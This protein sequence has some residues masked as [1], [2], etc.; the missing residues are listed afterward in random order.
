MEAVKSLQ[1]PA[2]GQKFLW[3]SELRGF[4]V[5][6][7]PS[8]LKTFILQ[9]RN[10]EDR[11]RRIAL[12]RFG[13][14]TVEQARVAAKVKLGD[15]AKGLDP[16]EGGGPSD[17]VTINEVCEWY[18]AEAGSGRLLGR[19]NRPIKTSTL[20]MDRSRI[21]MHIKPLLGHRQVKALKAIDIAAMQ[22]DI[23]AGKTARAK[24][25]GRGGVT[26]GGPGVAARTLTTLQ[27]L[28]SHAK[29]MDVV[30]DNP[31]V[32]VRKIA[33][34]KRD[35]RLSAGE[36]TKLGLAMRNSGQWAES[37]TALAAVRL[38]ILTGFRISEAQEL[39]RAWVNTEKRFVQFPDTKSGAQVRAIGPS[40]AALIAEQG[41]S[42]T[43]PYVF[44]ADVGDGAYTAAKRCLA[45]LCFNANITGV[46]PHTL[47]HTF[48][49]VAGDLG[50]SELTIAALLGHSARG[51]TQGY[52]HIDEALKLAAERTCEEIAGLLKIDLAS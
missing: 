30:A 40:A 41:S 37:P 15:I 4:G 3:D 8:G 42:G 46:T 22:A 28:L 48:A 5:R 13:V 47:R 34:K 31:S 26:R 16:A 39:Q 17:K 36:I 35:R 7:I 43:S 27:S 9:Y 52:V 21:E 10:A 25:D 18:L 44:P 6:V 51:V 50:F 11:S 23:A 20:S 14:M 2:S 32:G 1:K 29:R 45:R 38:M 12:G 33:S 49:S 24:T 19:N